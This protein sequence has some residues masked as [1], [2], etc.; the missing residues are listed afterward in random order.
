MSEDDEFP[1]Q[2]GSPSPT[3]SAS[4]R[5]KLLNKDAD[6]NVS[7][8]DEVQLREGDVTIEKDEVMPTYD[9]IE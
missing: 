9:I 6:S 5:D 7:D 3:K 4:F 2:P 8:T 1:A